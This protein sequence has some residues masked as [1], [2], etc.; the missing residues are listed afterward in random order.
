MNEI[1]MQLPPQQARSYPIKIGKDLLLQPEKWL[2]VAWQHKRLVIITDD[3]VN[4]LYGEKLKHT[5]SAFQ[6]LLFSFPA[7]ETAK[8]YQTQHALIEQMLKQYCTRETAILALGGGVVGDMAGFV[9]ATYLRGIPFIQLPTTLLAMVDSSVGGKTGINTAQ[10]KNLIGAFWQ[11]SCVIADVNC[12]KTLSRAHITQGLIEAVKMFL[13]SD[14]QSFQYVNHYGATLFQQ[15]LNVF[16]AIIASA[17]KIKAAVVM[18][19]EK[20]KNE[21]MILNFGHTIGHA[22]EKITNYAMSHGDAVALGILVE[23]KISQLLGLLSQDDYDSIQRLLA[24]W[25]INAH[26]LSEMDSTQ[27]IQ[28]TYHDKKNIADQVR[29]VLLSKIGEVYQDDH[30]FAHPVA[31]E[32]VKKALALVSGALLHNWKE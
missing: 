20:E 3:T 13:T 18:A 32:V 12:L 9:A 24:S 15:D 16:Q 19:D 6:P 10:G 2:P 30:L 5:L 11:P 26:S 7:G 21:R 17:V 27:L 25:D 28:A 4:S 8:H 29:Y 14:A 31:D 22:L 23:A 1:I